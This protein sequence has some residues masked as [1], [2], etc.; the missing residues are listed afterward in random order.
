MLFINRI[1]D[2]AQRPFGYDLFDEHHSPTP[3]V[4]DLSLHI[5]PQIHFFEVDVKW[6]LYAQYFGVLKHKTDN[7]YITF[8][9]PEIQ[10]CA[11]RN[12][13]FE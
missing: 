6:N 13:L 7:T 10:F 3:F 4:V 2:E 8:A 11:I 9:I 1:S 12:K 5:E